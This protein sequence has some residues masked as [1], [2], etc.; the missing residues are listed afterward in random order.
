MWI[1]TVYIRT[2]WM[3]SWY[4]SK[5]NLKFWGFFL[6]N[7]LGPNCADT[8]RHK[9]FDTLR[10][11]YVDSFV[12]NIYNGNSRRLCHRKLCTKTWYS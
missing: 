12:R 9:N 1:S 10:P 2:L 4:N 5:K 11:D 7:F 6:Y 3:K 8:F